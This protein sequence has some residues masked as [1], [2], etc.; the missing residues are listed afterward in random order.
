MLACKPGR[1]H[2]RPPWQLKLGLAP[3]GDTPRACPDLR[4]V[5]VWGLVVSVE[6]HVGGGV[7]AEKLLDPPPPLSA[8]PP[9]GERVMF[10]LS[11]PIQHVADKLP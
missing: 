2:K 5:R 1:R 9:P 8:P 4:A 6:E 7:P 3:T 10:H 11:K